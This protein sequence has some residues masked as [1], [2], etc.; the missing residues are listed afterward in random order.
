MAKNKNS[1]PIHLEPLP[2][3]AKRTLLMFGLD[4]S[5]LFKLMRTPK[6]RKALLITGRE[7]SMYGYKLMRKMNIRLSSAQYLLRE[8]EKQGLI[9]VIKEEPWRGSMLKRTYG[10]TCHGFCRLLQHPEAWEFFTEMRV[11]NTTLFPFIF[12]KWDIFEKMGVEGI[13][14]EHLKSLTGILDFFPRFY[15]EIYGPE[16]V[17]NL[18]FEK[19]EEDVFVREA[20]T[21]LFYDPVSILGGVRSNEDYERWAT[22]VTSDKEI[23]LLTNKILAARKKM[24]EKQL[25]NQNRNIDFLRSLFNNKNAKRTQPFQSTNHYMKPIPLKR[26]TSGIR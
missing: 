13:A 2:K 8:L 26:R 17:L 15:Q 3:I 20:L 12:G 11:K 19:W 24:L 5:S 22:V 23:F 18:H 25:E 9:R 1:T 10:L 14:L 7:G 4:P 16:G 21:T 6:A